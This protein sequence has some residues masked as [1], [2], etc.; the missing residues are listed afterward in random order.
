MLPRQRIQPGNL[1]LTFYR[2]APNNQVYA[3]MQDDDE[4]R[5]RSAEVSRGVS[6]KVS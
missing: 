5:G 4:G 1:D 3:D 6:S 2:L